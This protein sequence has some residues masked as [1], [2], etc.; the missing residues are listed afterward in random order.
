MEY[1]LHTSEKHRLGVYEHKTE[2]Y[3]AHL[4]PTMSAVAQDLFNKDLEIGYEAWVFTF[5]KESLASF[6]VWFM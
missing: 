6:A 5:L 1:I 3:V 2:S 4:K